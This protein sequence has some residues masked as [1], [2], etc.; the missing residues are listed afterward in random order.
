MNHATD[1]VRATTPAFK[2]EAFSEIMLTMFEAELDALIDL[3]ETKRNAASTEALL[4]R[5]ISADKVWADIDASHGRLQ[6][7]ML[8]ISDMMTA[9]RNREANDG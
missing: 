7:K 1:V 2:A 5:F 3:I 9:N 8:L 6:L 4:H